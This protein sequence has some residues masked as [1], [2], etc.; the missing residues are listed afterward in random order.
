MKKEITTITTVSDFFKVTAELDAKYFPDVKYFRD[1]KNA[2][3]VYYAT[4]LFNN[5]CLAYDKYI[6]RVAKACKDSKENIHA[7]ISK[8]IADFG[9]F[10]YKP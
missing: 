4:E 5:G 6:D 7:I 10:V 1:N 9:D 8:Y 2:V 3:K